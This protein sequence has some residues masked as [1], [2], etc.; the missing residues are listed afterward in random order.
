MRD[1][2]DLRLLVGAVG[3][4]AAGD[5]VALIALVLLVHDLTGSGLAVSALFAAT[6]IPVVALAPLAGLLADRVESVRLLVLASL[7]QAL[8]AAALAFTDS[9]VPVLFLTALLG[10]GSR[11]QPAGRV[12]AGAGG[13][14]WARTAGEGQRL[15]RDRSLRG[16]CDRPARGGG[17]H[18]RRR[19]AAGPAGE[20][21][22]LPGHRSGRRVH[23]HAPPAGARAVARAER[24]RPGRLRLP[25]A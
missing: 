17:P 6:M 1:S 18:R 21:G 3:L 8:V 5:F 19:L 16:L 10:L 15:G 23:A 13:G 4:S 14:R 12:R 11:D 24:S 7:G 22:Q 9:L 20:R 2:R 25:V